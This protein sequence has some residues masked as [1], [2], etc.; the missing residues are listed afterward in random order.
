MAAKSESDR[1]S[2]T[3]SSSSSSSSAS[4]DDDEERSSG[5]IVVA[6]AAANDDDESDK[7]DVDGRK[8]FLSRIP[9]T[10]D[11]DA[12]RRVLETNFGIGCVEDVSIAYHREND[13]KKKKEEE[14]DEGGN[15]DV[16]D[17]GHR[18][19]GFVTFVRRSY[20][21]RAI[22]SG[23]ARGSARPNSA[24]RHTLYVRPV[25]R[26]DEND[27]DEK[28]GRANGEGGRKTKNICFPWTRGRCPY[29]SKCKF[30]HEGEG[31]CSVAV[32]AARAEN[33]N[34]D[35]E[36]EEKKTKKK[37]K[38]TKKQPPARDDDDDDENDDGRRSKETKDKSRID[39]INL[40]NKGKCRK[41][42]RCPY[43]HEGS[44]LRGKM[45]CA[46][47]RADCIGGGGE[48]DG[49]GRGG[50]GGGGG[51]GGD[52][53]DDDDGGEEGKETKKRGRRI[54]KARQS[55]SVRVFGLNYDTTEKDVREYFANCGRIMEVTFPIWEDSGRSKGYCGVLF[56]SPKAVELA[57][58]LDGNE[59]H[60]RWLR[61]Q[62]G[63][64]Y[65][66]KWE[67]AEDER[68]KKNDN[69]RGGVGDDGR[70]RTRGV[71]E[72]R[73]TTGDEEPYDT[74]VGEYG[75]RVKRRK[76]HGFKE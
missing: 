5:G 33:E 65:L 24:R 34:G 64:M 56:T 4:S 35:E 25:F 54:D 19:F 49:G 3:S 59:L 71:G 43:R 14:E 50:G 52:E 10:F 75:Q 27:D 18:G 28:C 66:R 29:G 70:R 17:D 15:D 44:V 7:D 39:C 32:V 58:A 1:E 55:L 47:S 11:S 6:A 36:K 69:G 73:P 23:T 42:T 48:E 37:K 26:D 61:V 13:G 51:G 57:I 22:E 72:E 9:Q 63:K 30:V 46:K 8:A 74:L 16:N 38:K 2:P 45:R 20:L 40:K 76:R 67:E 31:G 21:R 53:K 68:R 60:G 41:G 12:V 62:E